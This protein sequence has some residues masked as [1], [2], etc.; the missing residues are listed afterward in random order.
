[1]AKPATTNFSRESTIDNSASHI[2]I[3]ALSSYSSIISFYLKEKKLVD[4]HFWPHSNIT[5]GHKSL[6][7][8]IKT[9]ITLKPSPHPSLETSP[10]S[11]YLFITSQTSTYH[12]ISHFI[13]SVYLLPFDTSSHVSRSSILDQWILFVIW[14]HPWFPIFPS[15][16]CSVIICDRS[17]RDM[18]SLLAIFWPEI[19]ALHFPLA[20]CQLDPCCH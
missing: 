5:E 17:L 7:K 4:G 19:P 10:H 6:I 15:G 11:S 9:E 16:Q 14:L 18:I 3:L 12:S 2:H 1:M 13:R 8:L 20:W